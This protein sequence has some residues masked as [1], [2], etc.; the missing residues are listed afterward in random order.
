M[1]LSGYDAIVIGTGFG[2]SACAYVLSNNGLKVLLLERGNWARR[3]ATDWNPK[4]ILID[5][6]YRGC[7]DILVKQ[8]DNKAH[9]SMAENE[10]VGGMSV[11]YGGASLRLRQNDFA[12]WPIAYDDLEPYYAQIEKLLGVHGE[13]GTDPHEPWRSDDYKRE[14]I[15]LTRPAQRIWN[16][17]KALG[18][19]P[20]KMPLAIN[21]EDPSRPVCI[22][23]LTCDGFPC[24]IEAKN[25]VTTNLLKSAQDAG[26]NILVGIQV[27]H[28]I[29]SQ[30]KI[31]SVVCVDRTTKKERILSAP[32]VVIAGGAIQSPGILLRSNLN[33]FPVYKG[34]G[35][36]LMRHCNAV[37]AGVFP[38][39]TNK[40]RVFHKQ[41]CFTDFYEDFRLQDGRATG[42]VQDIYSPDPVVLKHFAPKGFR[43]ASALSARFLQNLLCVAED[44]GQFEN[45]VS[46]TQKT[47]AMGIGQLAVD[48]QYSQRDCDRRDHLVYHAKKILRKAGALYFHTYAIDSFSHAVGSLRMGSPGDEKAVLDSNCRFQGI[49]NLFVVDGSVFPSSGGVNPS[50][51]IG[52]NALRVGAHISKTFQDI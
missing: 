49:E 3:D 4:A 51:T 42:V 26:A 1:V 6:T 11:F 27:S 48:H 28:L 45:R 10:V 17:G 12:D 5:K 18:L 30:G 29:E 22:R 35:H 47:D 16:A 46:L 38:F 32:I 21:F 15:P 40:E 31:Q 52:A 44:E 23:C 14:P 33:R 39:R 2:G 7:T 43:N 25:D 9:Q 20:F 36:H 41:V 34:I 24:Q 8:Y 13:G 37:V 19:S 50:L